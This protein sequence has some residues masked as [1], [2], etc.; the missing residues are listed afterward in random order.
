[1]ER[2]TIERLQIKTAEQRFL[3]VLE[4]KFREAPRVAQALLEEAQTCLFG[5]AQQ[6][7]PTLEVA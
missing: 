2:E 3:T 4:Q 6:M 5:A 7:R 1:M